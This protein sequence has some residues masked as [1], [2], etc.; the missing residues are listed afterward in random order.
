MGK[1]PS[2]WQREPGRARPVYRRGASKVPDG[3]LGSNAGLP[4]PALITSSL[5]CFLVPAM[6]TTLFDLI[7][8]GELDALRRLLAADPSLADARQ[9]DTGLG[10]LMFALYH[11]QREAA[12]LLRAARTPLTWEE[13]CA[14]GDLR[15]LELLLGRDP[16]LARAAS[17]DGFTAL[18][19]ACYFGRSALVRLLLASG[20]DADALAANPTRLRPLH[21]AAASRDLATVEAL[22]AARP[23]VDARQSRGFVAL[24]SAALNGD[25]AVAR[26]LLAAG[27]DRAL[28]A[29]DGRDALAF[30]REKDHGELVRLLEP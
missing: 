19:L 4:G 26:A 21:S 23:D 2:E 29:D 16:G 3:S 18:H 6:T 1:S 28:R 10:A 20:A 12:E 27:A 9:P 22:L 13:A 30:A 7:Q 25:L 5:L 17:A 11:H 8:R 24:H 14:L 15:R